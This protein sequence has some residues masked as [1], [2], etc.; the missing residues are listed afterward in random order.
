MSQSSNQIHFSDIK[1]EY[2]M[3]IDKI[4][5]KYLEGKK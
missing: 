2:S 5:K 1:E 4:M 3:L